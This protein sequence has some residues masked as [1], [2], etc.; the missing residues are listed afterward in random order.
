L[1][2]SMYGDLVAG[3]PLELDNLNGAVSSLGRQH[4]VE[5]PVNDLITACL[6]VSHRRAV[7]G[8]GRN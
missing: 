5:T 2:S 4:G 8:A 1:V 3:R 6:T 7:G